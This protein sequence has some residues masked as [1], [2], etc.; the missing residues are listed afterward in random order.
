MLRKELIRYLRKVDI[1]FLG[2]FAVFGLIGIITLIRVGVPGIMFLIPASIAFVNWSGSYNEASAFVRSIEKDG[3]LDRLLED[4]Q[5]GDRF[6]KGRVIQGKNYLI[7]KGH[8]RAYRTDEIIRMYD[9]TKKNGFFGDQRILVAETEDG[10]RHDL[11]FLST[12]GRND[13]DFR[14]L[15]QRYDNT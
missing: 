7:V 9:C 3:S 12:A 11:A 15:I 1:V 5:D 10:K 14:R 6:L 2:M 13:D 8:G 4:F